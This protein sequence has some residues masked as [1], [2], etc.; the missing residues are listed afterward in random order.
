[1]ALG[2]YGLGTLGAHNL[3]SIF[4]SFFFFFFC[5]VLSIDFGKALAISRHLQGK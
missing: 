5:V 1:M 3:L 4:I 2:D